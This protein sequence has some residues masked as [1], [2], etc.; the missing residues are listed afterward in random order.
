MECGE[1]S[2]SAGHLC[3]TIL[4]YKNC[5]QRDLDFSEI[6][7]YFLCNANRLMLYGNWWRKQLLFDICNLTDL[8]ENLTLMHQFCASFEN[9]ILFGLNF[10][11]A[12]L[13][14]DIPQ[15]RVWKLT[16]VYHLAKSL[17]M[18][19]ASHGLREKKWALSRVCLSHI[20]NNGTIFFDSFSLLWKSFLSSLK[21]KL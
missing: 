21:F 20:L 4:V 6:L 7:K 2:T 11:M 12:Y 16:R 5:P 14:L 17:E 3:P 1:G 10:L 18:Q 13:N 15:G 19:K 8:K 9:F